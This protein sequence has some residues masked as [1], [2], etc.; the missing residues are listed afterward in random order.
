MSISDYRPCGNHFMYL[1]NCLACLQNT[2]EHLV[3]TRRAH[4][5]AHTAVV[6]AMNE[7]RAG[8]LKEVKMHRDGELLKRAQADREYWEKAALRADEQLARAH[9]A[10]SELLETYL[11]E[12][13]GSAES[14][15]CVPAVKSARAALE[16]RATTSASDA[17]DQ[18][19]S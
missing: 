13:T 4:A 6:D 15:E 9:S 7:E 18:K 12:W 19:T 17:S 16:N 11:I 5:E 3:E 1:S 14:A 2:T 10:L 8:L